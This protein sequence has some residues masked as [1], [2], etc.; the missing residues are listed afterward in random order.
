MMLFSIIPEINATTSQNI[1]DLVYKI[2]M[3][4][5]DLNKHVFNLVGTPNTWP[6]VFT[7]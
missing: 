7:F 3:Y 1:Y 4:P 5:Y 6:Y 2:L